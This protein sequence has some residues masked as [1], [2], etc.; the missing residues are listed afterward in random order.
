MPFFIGCT[1][2]GLAMSA[3]QFIPYSL[4]PDL[5]DYYEYKTGERHE[6]VFFGL[7][8]AVHQLGIAVAGLVLGVVL[9]LS[10]YI[11]TAA[12]QSGSALLGVKLIFSAIPG[13]FLIAAALVLQKFEVT[14][15]VYLE[16]RAA[17]DQKS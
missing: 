14:R 5:V 10:G 4:V 6:S 12:V 1:L 8:I 13:F 3:Y 2:L 9:S 11:G 17:L 7:W 16:V 15:K